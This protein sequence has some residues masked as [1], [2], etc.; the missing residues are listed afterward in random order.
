MIFETN[1]EREAFE[2][3]YDI[4][5]EETSRRGCNDLDSKEINTFKDIMIEQ[6]GEE[7]NV[8][9]DFDILQWLKRQIK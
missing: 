8:L 9:Y 7:R 5:S 6:D 4:A 1:L 3:I 2:F